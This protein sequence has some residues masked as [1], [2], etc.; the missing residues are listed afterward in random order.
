MGRF[1]LFQI[2][3]SVSVPTS[4][5]LQLPS[6]YRKDVYL[7]LRLVGTL[8]STKNSWN[9]IFAYTWP[10]NR[11]KRA[12]PLFLSL[13]LCLACDVHENRMWLSAESFCLNKFGVLE[14]TGIFGWNQLRNFCQ[15]HTFE[16]WKVKCFTSL[17]CSLLV[18]P[19]GYPWAVTRLILQQTNF[20]LAA[21]F[22]G[23]CLLS[24]LILLR[25]SKLAS[26]S[27]FHSYRPQRWQ[28][29]NQ[30]QFIEGE[31]SFAFSVL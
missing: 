9:V 7:P 14:L 10:W 29:V 18:K 15:L 27:I 21:S 30:S 28:Q 26:V 1:Q 12:L 22:W 31:I 20:S 16:N 11:A 19:F 6:E 13:S 24:A 23:I 5:Q 25:R 4:R 3:S 2:C 17:R 8:L